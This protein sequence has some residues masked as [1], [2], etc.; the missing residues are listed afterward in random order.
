LNVCGQETLVSIP[1]NISVDVIWTDKDGRMSMGDSILLPADYNGLLM[2]RVKESNI[3]CSGQQVIQVRNEDDIEIVKPIGDTI[4]TCEDQTVLIVLENGRPQDDIS[5]EYFPKEH[6]VS[7]DSTLTPTFFGFAD[8]ITTLKYIATNQ[9]GCV[10]EDSLIINVREFS[11]NL[12]PLQTI[13]QDNPTVI[14]PNFNPDFEYTWSPSE[15]L[16][17]PNSGNP[18]ILISEPTTYQVTITNGPGAGACQEIRTVELDLFPTFEFESSVDMTLCSPQDLTLFMNANTEVEYEWSDSS[19][20]SEIIGFDS[21]LTVFVDQEFQTLYG[22]AVDTFGCFKSNAI[23]IVIPS[24]GL[25]VPDTTLACFDKNFALVVTDTLG[26]TNLTYEWF[27][28][29]IIIDPNDPQRPV[30]RAT[31][32]VLL[33]GVVTNESGCTDTLETFIQLIDLDAESIFA[34]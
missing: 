12:P 24:F 34:T 21:V 4:R 32:D 22:R 26:I 17:D 1:P 28:E 9:F 31:E 3:G 18:D 23:D 7:G 6:I 33:I 16:S 5:I 14:N 2:V 15:G 20:F 30:V 27:P 25:V 10:L 29:E 11:V 19:N 8:T 13:C